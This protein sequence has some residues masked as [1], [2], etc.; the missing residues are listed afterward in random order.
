MSKDK[1]KENE[2]TVQDTNERLK[3]LI[4]KMVLSDSYWGFIFSKVHRQPSETLPSIM[5]V[6]PNPNGTLTLFY[7]PELIKQTTDESIIKIIEHEGMHVLNKH[8]PRLLR[9]LVDEMSPIRKYQKSNIWNWAADVCVNTQMKMPKKLE[10]C[11]EETSVLHPETF[12]L[13]DGLATE[14]YY[15][16]LSKQFE[17]Y[18]EENKDKC[19]FCGGK[20]KDHIDKDGDGQG[21][22]QGQGDQEGDKDGQGEGD[23]E[24]QG[25]GGGERYCECGGGHVGD[26]SKW[27]NEQIANAPDQ[28][29]LARKLECDTANIVKEATKNFKNRGDLPAHIQQLIDELLNP[30]RLPY[31]QMIQK[32][33][34]GSK[35]SKFKRSSTKINRKRTWTFV[36]GEEEG[37][38][39]ISPFPGRTR[40][41]SF[42]I[43]IL[44]DTSGSM[45]EDDIKEG[46]S[47]IKN[48]IE[49]DRNCKVTVIENDTQINK[50]YECKKISEI[51]FN[52]LGR[53]G[54]VLGPGLKRMS[55]I[56]PDITLVF[57]DG[58]IE[59]VRDLDKKLLPK[60]IL[61]I[62]TEGGHEDAVKGT[63]YVVKIE[64]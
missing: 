57:T 5:G 39:D 64:R 61:W 48:L 17:K 11:G 62:I 10:I 41:Y 60:K 49:N 40:D 6:A 28:H 3:E 34:R 32:L 7:R 13:E 24:G 59:N 45:S 54:T 56:N 2:I 47:G 31:H 43:G 12:N 50:E 19:P 16:T 23:Q 27:F 21:D 26:H 22:G 1:K 52:V 18:Q 42:N 53:G 33:V 25:Q 38:P 46:L 29:A 4:A 9:I 44:I 20:L 15:D 35:L 55:E 51:Q 37:I 63:G 58:Y 36:V 14:N 30:P 8:V